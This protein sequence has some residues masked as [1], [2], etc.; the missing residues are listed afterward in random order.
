MAVSLYLNLRSKTPAILTV[1]KG[2]QVAGAEG[3]TIRYAGGIE[4]GSAGAGVGQFQLSDW[5]Q[6]GRS[7]KLGDT[8]PG[9][10]YD[11]MRG[12]VWQGVLYGCDPSVEFV[13]MSNGV[14]YHNPA[15]G[16]Q[17]AT[18]WEKVFTDAFFWTGDYFSWVAK[19]DNAKMWRDM[20]KDP[21]Y[22]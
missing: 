6:V 16:M 15:Y 1:P 2:A 22:W 17:N 8:S 10:S 19:T 18:K 20:F 3:A 11:P 13:T 14:T 5:G 4:T 21:F 9:F 12:F 7:W